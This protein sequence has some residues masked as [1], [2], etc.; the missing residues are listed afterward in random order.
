M[1]AI[2]GDRLT[3]GGAA[4]PRGEIEPGNFAVMTLHRPSNVDDPK[5]LGQLMDFV[6]DE[7]VESLPLVW[8]I[9]PRTLK[10][11]KN[12]GLWE[13][14]QQ[15]RNI[16]VLNPV[17]NKEDAMLRV[18][19]RVVVCVLVCV[20]CHTVQG[21]DEDVYDAA[22]AVIRQYNGTCFGKPLK[23]VEIAGM[24][25]NDRF[26]DAMPGLNSLEDL[27]I[28]RCR[29]SDHGLANVKKFPVLRTLSLEDDIGITT[30]GIGHLTNLLHLVKLNIA[31][32]GLDPSI[33]PALAAMP[34]LRHLYG[35]PGHDWD[36]ALMR[37]GAT[38]ITVMLSRGAP[39]PRPAAIG[40][41]R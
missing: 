23:R 36:D 35:D 21:G 25:V 8:P 39:R 33:A 12:A 37:A 26:L 20:L 14:V 10:N 15:N 28:Q 4:E 1:A 7:L 29:L 41:F 3:G 34:E 32:T 18:A 40:G 9:H 24:L 27:R 38:N 19:L 30:E 16:V 31:G 13:R 2:L 17:G 6:T 11:L 5:I 22:L